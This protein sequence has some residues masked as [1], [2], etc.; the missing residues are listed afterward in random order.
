MRK[1]RNKKEST[2]KNSFWKSMSLKGRMSLV[3][4][5][6]SFVSILGCAIFWYIPLKLKWISRLTIP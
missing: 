4:G 3:L 5:I 1:D 6:V 2:Q